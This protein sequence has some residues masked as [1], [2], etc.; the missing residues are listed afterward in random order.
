MRDVLLGRS[1]DPAFDL[2]TLNGMFQFRHRVFHDLL[3]WEVNSER[4][5]ERDEYD[6]LNPVYL[7][8]KNTVGDIEGFRISLVILEE[9]E[10][11]QLSS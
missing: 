5:M 3:G 4:G 6:D 11:G 7:I 2:P 8:A 10:E 9:L 1:T